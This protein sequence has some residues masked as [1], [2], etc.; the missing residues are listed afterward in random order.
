MYQMKKNVG[1][2]ILTVA[3]GSLLFACS[4]QNA[5]NKESTVTHSKKESSGQKNFVKETSISFIKSSQNKQDR[6]W[7]L[8]KNDYEEQLPV[9]KLSEISAI[10]HTKNGEG[11]IY[12][13]DVDN[14]YLKDVVPLSND[15]ILSKAKELDEQSFKDDF[16]EDLEY[17]DNNLKLAQETL[18]K[19]FNNSDF[20]NELTENIPLIQADIDKLKAITYQEPHAVLLK[21]QVKTDNTG[22]NTLS[23]EFEF[24]YMYLQ[25]AMWDIDPSYYEISYDDSYNVSYTE[26]FGQIS[27]H[28]PIA[29]TQILDS[30]FAGFTNDKFERSIVTTVKDETIFA[31]LDSIN[32]KNVIDV[33]E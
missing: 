16:N 8:I 18:E 7:Y 15:E 5:T 23:E 13:V 1:C 21:A 30:L 20:R 3:M 4:N 12:N 6:I 11:T 28:Y 29:T 32:T 26:E 19:D 25:S 33:D 27:I 31:E 14:F 9:T 17:L 22:Q 10:I 24:P 2:I